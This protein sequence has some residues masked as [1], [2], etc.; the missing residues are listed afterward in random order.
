MRFL[1]RHLQDKLIFSPTSRKDLW[2]AISIFSPSNN[3]VL[4]CVISITAS[5]CIPMSLFCKSLVHKQQKQFTVNYK[6]WKCKTCSKYKHNKD[7]KQNNKKMHEFTYIQC[8]NQLSSKINNYI[9]HDN[10]SRSKV[11]ATGTVKTVS[12]FINLRKLSLG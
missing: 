7:S 2:I 10:N 6:P 3:S 11:K 9:F 4:W 8:L 1:W 5:L 12:S